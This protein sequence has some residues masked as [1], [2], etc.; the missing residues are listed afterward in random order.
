MQTK[1]GRAK[2]KRK[3]PTKGQAVG[4]ALEILGPD[5]KPIQIQKYLKEERGVDVSTDSISTYKSDI[6]RRAN[7]QVTH[8]VHMAPA[9]KPQPTAAATAAPDTGN[10]DINDIVTVKDL[11]GRVGAGQLKS[12]IDVM[13]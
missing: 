9:A 1:N 2:S 4:I 8:S 7:G 13:A 3:H 12:L 5:A 10:F 6:R 11:M